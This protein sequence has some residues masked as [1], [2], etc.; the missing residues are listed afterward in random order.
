MSIK[1]NIKKSIA[2][3]ACAMALTGASVQQSQAA[4]QLIML[5]VAA[6]H[7]APVAGAWAAGGVIATA[8]TLGLY[9][10]I[11]RTT[12]AGDFANLGGPG[13]SKPMGPLDNALPP[14][15][16]GAPKGRGR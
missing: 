10:I 16:C 8:L 3:A 6:S 9:D 5:P 2:V 14:P 4:P 11:R 13:F 1:S 15:A 12:C 7:G